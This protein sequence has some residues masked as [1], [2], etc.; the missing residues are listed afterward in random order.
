MIDFIVQFLA[1]SLLL[2]GLWLMG[3][4]KL[5]GPILAC[6]AEVF[7]TAVGIMHNA[8]SIV[9]IGAVLFIIQGRNAIKWYK[10]GRNAVS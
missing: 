10:E 4:K 5:S 6:L 1:T 9:V 3:N 2:V 8:W 7:T